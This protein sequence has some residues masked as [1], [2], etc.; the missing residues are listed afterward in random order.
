MDKT[1]YFRQMRIEYNSRDFRHALVDHGMYGF[2]GT[3][4]SH[5][6]HGAMDIGRGNEDKIMLLRTIHA[7]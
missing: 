5:A 7:V 6:Q 2:A 1:L 3:V 4:R